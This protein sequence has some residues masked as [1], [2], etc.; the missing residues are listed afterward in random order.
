MLFRS[1]E[2]VE[3][4]AEEILLPESDVSNFGLVL[5]I[6]RPKNVVVKYTTYE[7]N[8]SQIRLE[9]I[10]SRVIQH[11]IDRLNGIDFKSKVSELTLN[12]SK[13]ALDKKVKRYVRN[14]MTYTK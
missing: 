8:E 13:K 3:Y 4:S 1:P 2:I 5:K 12:R 14:I 6:K 9:G 10:T 7:G 11:H